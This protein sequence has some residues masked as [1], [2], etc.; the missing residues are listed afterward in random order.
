[1]DFE[2][3]VRSLRNSMELTHGIRRALVKALAL[4]YFL[5]LGFDIVA[6]TT[7]FA[8]STIIMTVFEFPT[9]AIADY[10]S[11]KKSIMISFFLLFT[12]FLGIFLFT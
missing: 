5:S 8:V 7:L 10:D 6:V 12:S 11:R 2:T 1:M 3:Q 4:V 9:G